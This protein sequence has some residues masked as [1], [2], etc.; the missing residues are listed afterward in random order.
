MFNFDPPGLEPDEA[1]YIPWYKIKSL[2]HNPASCQV[3]IVHWNSW[4]IMTIFNYFYNDRLFLS[5][6]YEDKHLCIMNIKVGLEEVYN[7]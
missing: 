6:D 7:N 4:L 2:F 5:L 3:Q 1:H